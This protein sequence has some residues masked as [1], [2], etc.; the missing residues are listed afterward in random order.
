MQHT[1]SK[2]QPQILIYKQ[3]FNGSSRLASSLCFSASTRSGKETFGYMAQ[4]FNEEEA[5][6]ITQP[7]V[8]KH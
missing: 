6:S 2:L 4:V 3:R 5:L 8:S 1:V 7:T